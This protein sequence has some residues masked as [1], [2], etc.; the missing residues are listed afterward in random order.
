MELRVNV[1]LDTK[2][3]AVPSQSFGYTEM[4]HE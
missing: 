4:D 3:L 1:L 2:R